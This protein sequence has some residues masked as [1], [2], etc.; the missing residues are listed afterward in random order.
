MA[1][2]EL[3]LLLRF[4]KPFPSWPATSHMWSEFG[5]ILDRI[6]TLSYRRIASS[7]GFH[8]LIDDHSAPLL[9]FV[10]AKSRLSAAYPS[11]YV[12]VVAFTGANLSE[13]RIAARRQMAA[14]P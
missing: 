2:P 10:S 6:P 12:G 11:H 3:H 7:P 1:P 8:R 13:C 9:W 5:P 4:S 14:M